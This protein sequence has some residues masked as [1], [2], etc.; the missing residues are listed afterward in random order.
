MHGSNE[1]R[2]GHCRRAGRTYRRQTEDSARLRWP[3]YFSLGPPAAPPEAGGT[4][5]L[6][7]EAL[8]SW[9]AGN[10]VGTPEQVCEKL[11]AYADLGVAGVIP[12]CSDYPDT[13]TL[14]RLANEVMPN[15]R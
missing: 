7:G 15:F 9:R 12:W 14:T 6:W 13:E 8:A 3:P 10:L 5:S 2:T 4:R 11:R 1:E